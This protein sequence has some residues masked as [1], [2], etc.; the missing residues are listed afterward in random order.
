MNSEHAIPRLN[1]RQLRKMYIELN[2]TAGQIA[3]QCCR[4]ESRVRQ[5]LN[6]DEI[7][8]SGRRGVQ[9]RSSA[10]SETV[11]SSSA[12]RTSQQF[13]MRRF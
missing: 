12:E 9:A 8:K 4:T 5:M 13:L 6:D 1:R 7:Y 3:S 10:H 2:M 11:M